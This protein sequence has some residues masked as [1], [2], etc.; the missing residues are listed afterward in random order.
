MALLLMAAVAWDSLRFASAARD[1]VL[2]ADAEM[3]KQEERLVKLLSSSE[4]ASPEMKHSIAT[5]EAAGNSQ[6]R[7]D[8]FDELVASFRQTM[9]NAIDATNP[10]DRR[11][12]D[13]IAGAINRRE[14]A[15]KQYDVEW[16]SYRE[17]LSG[18]R[19]RIARMLSAQARRDWSPDEPRSPMQIQV[20]TER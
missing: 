8:A 10:L 14:V 15:E 3:R 1:R 17:A 2:L 13:D 11:F 20:E 18:V 5:Y 19:G 9:S 6:T 7:H 4:Q 12:M 16:A